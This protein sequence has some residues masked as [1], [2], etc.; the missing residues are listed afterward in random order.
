MAKANPH[1]AFRFKLQINDV[2]V[3]SFQEVGGIRVE[4]KV[5]TV[6]EGGLNSGAHKLP[7]GTSYSDITLKRG[8]IDDHLWKWHQQVV[9]GNFS[10]Q[11]CSIILNNAQGQA[12]VTWNIAGA[13]PTVW[14]GPSLSAVG[15]EIATESLTLA[16]AGI[17]RS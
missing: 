2:P 4:T 16:H 13:F 3:G 17:S 8:Y 7:G 6:N 5:E 9:S 10:R 15:N 11:N 1:S 14:E 12:A